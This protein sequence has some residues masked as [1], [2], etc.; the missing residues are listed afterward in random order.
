MK[1]ASTS[2]HERAVTESESRQTKR[3]RN[4]ARRR[5]RNAPAVFSLNHV[6]ESVRERITGE[7]PNVKSPTSEHQGEMK[8]QSSSFKT[9]LKT[10]GAEGSS[11]TVCSARIRRSARVEVGQ[12]RASL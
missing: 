10:A 3:K 8:A 7:K 12:P 1:H 5:L 4:E 6:H 11:S 9:S 2:N